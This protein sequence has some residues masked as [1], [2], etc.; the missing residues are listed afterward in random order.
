M[1]VRTGLPDCYRMRRKD[2]GTIMAEADVRRTEV[3]EWVIDNI[4]V[5]AVEVELT[6]ARGTRQLG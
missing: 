1:G 5:R 3:H 2:C 6:I 4:N